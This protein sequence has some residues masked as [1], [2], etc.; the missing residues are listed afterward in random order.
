MP[1]ARGVTA[2][3]VADWVDGRLIGDETVLLDGVAT[4]PEATPSELSY[5]ASAAFLPEFRASAAGAVLMGPS[6][7]DEP[8]GPANRIVV[9]EPLRA[10]ADVLNRLYPAPLPEPGVHPTAIVG[11]GTHLG[12][13]VSIGPHVVIGRCST[14]GDGVRL[15]PGT[16]LGDGVTIGADSRLVA[17]VTVYDGCRIGARALIHAGVVIGADGFG[18]E[19]GPD[20]PFKIPHVGRVLIEEDVEIGA[21]SAVDRGT[22][23]DTVIGAGT[24]V[25]NL[26]QIGHNTK[27]GRRCLIAGAVAIGGSSILEDDVILGGQ[28]GIAGHVTIG[29]GAKVGGQAGVLK[30]L[31]AGGAYSGTPTRPLREY[32]RMTASTHRLARIARVLEEMAEEHERGG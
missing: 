5:L 28:V 21:N 31:P 26:V 7:V 11:E 4:L 27:I 23:T 9:D 19:F 16:V 13:A 14:V 25:D 18:F 12:E 32:Q 22:L 30:S 29:A 6:F 17:R 1:V 24:K 20:G 2:R 8:G 10:L 15:G 3:A